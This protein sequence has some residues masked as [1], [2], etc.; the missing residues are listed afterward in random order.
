MSYSCRELARLCSGESV[1]HAAE[2]N[3]KIWGFNFQSGFL[4]SGGAGSR[5]SAVMAGRGEDNAVPHAR[6]IVVL[7]MQHSP[8]PTTLGSLYHN[9]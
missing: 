1:I 3:F 7:I 6:L 2:G 4:T 9:S 5:N 8:L